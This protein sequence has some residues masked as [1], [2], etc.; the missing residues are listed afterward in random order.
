MGWPNGNDFKLPKEDALECLHD[1]IL[2]ETGE[3]ISAARIED[4]L[5]KKWKALSV[6]AHSVHA[7]HEVERA[8]A[9][10]SKSKVEPK[11]E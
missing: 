5:R 1:L 2:K 7:A 6:F 3:F 10:H 8:M 11:D 9:E 4:L